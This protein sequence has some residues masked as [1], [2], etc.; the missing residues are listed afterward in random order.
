MRAAPAVLRDPQAELHRPA[1][2]DGA[3]RGRGGPLPDHSAERPHTWQ[4]RP[5]SRC[6]ICS[7]SSGPRPAKKFGPFRKSHR[8]ACCHMRAQAGGLWIGLGACGWP[9]VAAKAGPR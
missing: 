3:E 7:V 6:P 2:D 1:P 8:A 5:I 4:W 9:G